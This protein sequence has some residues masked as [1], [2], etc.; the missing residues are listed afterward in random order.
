MTSLLL[1]EPLGAQRPRLSSGPSFSTSAGEEAVELAAEA[2]LHLD[3]WQSWFLEQSLGERTDGKWSAFEVALLV[4]RQ[5]GKGSILEARELAGLFLFG[6][7]LIIHSAH[8]LKT[9]KEHFYR[10]KSLIDGSGLVDPS[11]VKY[12]ASNEEWSITLPDGAK[13]HFLARSSGGGR[14]FTGDA[15]ILDE[16][17]NLSEDAM[18]ALLPTMAA[19]SITGNPQIWY[20][21]SAPLRGSHVLR[22]VRDRGIRGEPR[23]CFAEWSAHPDMDLTSP[24]ARIMA[25]PALGRRIADE[26]V[27]TGVAA[28][29]VE[30]GAVEFLGVTENIKKAD[31]ISFEA[32]KS[33]ESAT[34]EIASDEVVFAVSTGIDGNATAIAVCGENAD[35][36]P[37]VE[38]IEY[39]PGVSWS[40]DRLLELAGRWSSAGEAVDPSTPTKRILPALQDG[41]LE[42]HL[43]T[44]RDV[45]IA[46]E[47][48]LDRVTE[49]PLWHPPAKRGQGEVVQ[50]LEVA[51]KRSIGDRGGWGWGRSSTDIDIAPLEA[52]TNALYMWLSRASRAPKKKQ[53]SGVVW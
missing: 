22:R 41:G 53:R 5:N 50:A 2:G 24:E 49:G 4:P 44:S 36:E 21:S 31:V 37:H 15:V 16:A 40:S 6:E 9:S 12:R 34:S 23:L 42:P 8:E 13:L 39:N 27:A 35:G 19:K 51:T 33:R 45:Q 29:G 38:L 20:T 32:W 48:F 3:D 11:T 26:F 30:K 47:L 28:L 1:S 17:Y 14:G 10:M 25:N 46:C 52:I 18:A 7:R 43:M